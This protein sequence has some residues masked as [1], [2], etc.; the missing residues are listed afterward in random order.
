[1]TLADPLCGGFRLARYRP[2][3]R[4]TRPDPRLAEQVI[5]NQ[6]LAHVEVYRRV[7]GDAAAAADTVSM[8]SEPLSAATGVTTVCASSHVLSPAAE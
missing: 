2:C 6:L 7:K 5:L 8:M 4:S 1:M 3:W